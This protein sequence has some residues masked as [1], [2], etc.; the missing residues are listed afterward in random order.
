MGKHKNSTKRERTEL[1]KRL[2]Y[3][4]SD[5]QKFW[6][7]CIEFNTNIKMLSK[8]GLNWTDLCIHQIESL[9]TLKEKTLEKLRQKMEREMM[10]KASKLKKEEQDKHYSDNFERII[11]DKLSLGECL[12]EKELK[13]LVSEG[14]EVDRVIG[15]NERWSRTITSIIKLFD[16][17]Y[18]IKWEEGL[19]EMQEDIFLNQPYEVQLNEYEKVI[20]V[21]EWVK[22]S[23]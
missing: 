3:T 11:S 10:I 20:V 9:P 12:S 2:G 1:L 22:T 16:K 13:T 14:N 15:S 23:N 17:Y 19:T 6:D 5:M 18:A 21:K 7:E 4:E 8:A